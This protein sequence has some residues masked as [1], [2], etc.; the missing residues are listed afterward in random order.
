MADVFI[1]ALRPDAT[2]SYAMVSALLHAVT[3]A[4]GNFHLD[5]LSLGEF[6]V[7]ALPHNSALDAGGRPNRSGFANTFY[8]GA[9]DFEHAEK[10]TVATAAAPVTANITLKAAHLST[11]S[12][13]VTGSNGQALSGPYVEIAHGDGFFGLDSRGVRLGA[14]GTFVTPALQPGTYFFVFH[15]S[16]WPPP[17][18]VMPLVSQAK[19]VVTGEDIANVRVKTIHT[20]R[21]TG[22]FIVAAADRAA[23]QLSALNVSE[24]LKTFDG[25]PG[26][27]PP[28]T[29]REDL[30]FEFET[31]PGTGRFRVTTPM[32][33]SVKA[34]RVNGV[35]VTDG[36]VDFPE[37]QN[38]TGVEIEL[39]ER[40]PFA[41]RQPRE[42][43]AQRTDCQTRRWSG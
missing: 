7:V 4:L 41:P 12:G 35:D 8:P 33:F 23:L 11:V 19:V 36:Y 1:T 10:V 29:I 21:V 31:W 39:V 30:S 17:R 16:A 32:Q 26:P 25:N 22:R 24:A 43:A 40:Q 42:G 15:E 5:G 13:I 20:V 3:D 28:A 6:Y 27:R 18:G 37:G 38:M 14:D 34:V 9:T 2:R